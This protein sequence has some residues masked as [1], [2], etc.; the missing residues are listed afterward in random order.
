MSD[1]LKENLD[2]L[3]GDIRTAQTQIR[4][5]GQQEMSHILYHIV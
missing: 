1:D 2:R 3:D 5:Y 4:K